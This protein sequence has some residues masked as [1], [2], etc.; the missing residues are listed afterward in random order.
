[1]FASCLCV[2]LYAWCMLTCAYLRMCVHV[3]VRCVCAVCVH[4]CVFA[5][6][7]FCMCV[8]ICVCSWVCVPVC[9]WCV[10]CVCVCVKQGALHPLLSCP[11]PALQLVPLFFRTLLRDQDPGREIARGGVGQVCCADLS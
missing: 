1:M 5:C 7:C 9:V 11:S 6:V 3:C 8:C 2:H 4:V 10:V